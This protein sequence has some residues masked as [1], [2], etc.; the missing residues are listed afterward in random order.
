MVTRYV[1]NQTLDQDLERSDI[2]EDDLREIAQQIVDKFRDTAP[3][4]TGAYA[5]SAEAQTGRLG[6]AMIGR[7]VVK[8]YKA[9]WLEYGTS[10][11]SLQ[12][13]LRRAIEAAG[14]KQPESGDK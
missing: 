13:P 6:T 5:D 11:R 3:R 1:P 4:K 9:N 7:V 14:Y 2:F 8:D 12:A 10:Q